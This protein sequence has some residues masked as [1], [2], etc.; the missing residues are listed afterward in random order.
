MHFLMGVPRTFLSGCQE[1]R[2]RG[3]VAPNFSLMYD[4]KIGAFRPSKGLDFYLRV[5]TT[6]FP[7]L[8]HI[9]SILN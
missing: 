4:A 2:S 7:A 1:R 9:L 3:A 6:L 5:Y 8:M